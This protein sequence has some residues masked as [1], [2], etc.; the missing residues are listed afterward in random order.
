MD[1]PG[2]KVVHLV[3]GEIPLLFACIDQF[4]NIFKFVVKSQ[5]K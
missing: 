2:K 1:V 5:K 4:L 3:I